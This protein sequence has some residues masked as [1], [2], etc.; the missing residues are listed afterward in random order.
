MPM[1]LAIARGIPG[2]PLWPGVTSIASAAALL[3]VLAVRRRRAT[4]TLCNAVFLLNV[5][6]VLFALW[7]SNTA[8]AE[9][10]RTWVPFQAN[11]LGIVTVALLAPQLWVGG[12]SIAAYV[13]AALV[14]MGTFSEAARSRFALGEPWATIAIGVFA[15]VLLGYRLRGLALEREL[16]HAHAEVETT[17]KF[18]KI[19][20]SIRDLANTPLQTITF[21]VETARTRHDDLEPV[22]RPVDRALG[23]LRDLGQRLR[24]YEATV[25]WTAAE[26][27]FDPMATLE[28]Q[29]GSTRS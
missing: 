1:D 7:F 2:V 8:Y 5:A 20:L 22:L 19:L 26:E 27:A 25:E 14:Q 3:G 28:T 10:G 13:G 29:S 17:R 6:A 16:A 9:S 21:A 4:L 18:A 12:V 11:K 23:T 24:Q 15:V